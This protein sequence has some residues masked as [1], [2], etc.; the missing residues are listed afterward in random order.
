MTDGYAYGHVLTNVAP[1]LP[2]D[3]FDHDQKQRAQEVIQTCTKEGFNPPINAE[4]I[5]SG[6]SRLNTLLCADI[7]NNR[8]GLFIEEEKII[9]LPP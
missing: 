6:N 4:G 1:S 2:K 3:Y 7:F 8:H 5:L 9:E